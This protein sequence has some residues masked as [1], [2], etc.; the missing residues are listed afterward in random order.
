VL[1]EDQAKAAANAVMAPK[2]AEAASNA[3]PRA[4]RPWV[5]RRA[6]SRAMGR[7]TGILALGGFTI[8]ILAATILGSPALAGAGG[9]WGAGFL[10]G[11]YLDRRYSLETMV[12]VVI[13]A[14]VLGYSVWVMAVAP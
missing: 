7:W 6:L 1:T 5:L 13:T 8:G 2:E 3:R 14:A 9:G 11:M 4:P 12:L 10:V